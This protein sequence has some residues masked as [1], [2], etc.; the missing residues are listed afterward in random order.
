VTK[1][2]GLTR[3]VAL[4]DSISIDLYPALD[5]AGRQGIAPPDGVGA[6]SL[7]YRNQ[8][9][10]WPEFTGHDLLTHHGRIELTDLTADG[11]TTYEV[12]DAQLPRLPR[13]EGR[14]LA[15]ITAGGNDLL[16]LFG[17][18]ESEGRR[19]LEKTGENLREIVR[20]VRGHF[21]DVTI[22]V[23]TVYDPSDGTG[24]TDDALLDFGDG[25]LRGLILGWLHAYND[26][27]RGIA[28]DEGC[29]L[30]DIHEHFL[31]HGTTVGDP[32]ERWYWEESIIEPS[33]L[34]ASE[35]RRLWLR[36]LGL[37]P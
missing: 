23:G 4:G 16:W 32:V 17:S 30:A 25:V 34:G 20:R 27:V 22:I 7:L 3:Y 21:A 26:A 8:D 19:A 24:Q 9:R 1:T 14:A 12:L 10:L 2:S 33:A 31:G 6:V 11:A 13:D 18:C 28:A 15:T 35:V 29:L 36:C 37:E 5:L